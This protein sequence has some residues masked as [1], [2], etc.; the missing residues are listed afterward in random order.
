MPSRIMIV[1]DEPSILNVL[2]TLL[3]VEGYEVVAF[4]DGNEAVHAIQNDTFDLLI[5][6]IRM[7][8][9]SGME[10]LK[11]A[12]ESAPHM[13]VIMVTAVCLEFC[14]GSPVPYSI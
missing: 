1:D 2:K 12:Y 6:D 4:Q 11:L 13:A 8:P 10:M 3:S 14:F 7:T 9:I 5:S